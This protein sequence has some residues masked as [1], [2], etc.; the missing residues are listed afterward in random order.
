MA[1]Q[2]PAFEPLRTLATAAMLETM[3]IAR[4]ALAILTV[5]AWAFLLLQ[6]L[7]FTSLLSAAILVPLVGTI[8]S[9]WIGFFGQRH[10]SVPATVVLEL[11]LLVV[12]GFFILV[13][14]ASSAG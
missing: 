3:R 2:M 5:E 1:H 10:L 11:L 8:V 14:M 4:L 7:G 12:A 13:V 9:V 6:P